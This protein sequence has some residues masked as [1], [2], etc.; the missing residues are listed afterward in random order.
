MTLVMAITLLI[1]PLT[2]NEYPDEANDFVQNFVQLISIVVI[3]I[4]TLFAGDAIVSEFQG[5]TGYLLFPNPVK[6]WTLYL[7]KYLAALVLAVAL[8]GIYYVIVVLLGL[9]IT[10]GMTDKALW[11]FLLTCLFAASTIAATSATVASGARAS[12]SR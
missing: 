3:V 9:G 10:G 11:S 1:T 6:R 4:A 2:G 7:G 8:L 12:S 5:R